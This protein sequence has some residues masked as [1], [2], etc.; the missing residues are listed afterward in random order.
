MRTTKLTISAISHAGI[1]LVFSTFPPIIRTAEAGPLEE[2]IVTAQKREQS[3]QEVGVS[4]TAFGADG[5]RDLGFAESTDIAAQTPGLNIGTPV[6]EGNNP[7]IVLR[8][9][10]LNDFND[11]NEGPV[12]LYK[13]GVYLG[14]M[15]GQTF[16]LFDI[17]RVEV[18][19]GPQGTLYGR[20]TTGGLV[21]FISNRPTEENDASLGISYGSY[22]QLKLEGALGGA[23]SEDIRVRF[24]MTANDHEGYVE[25]RIG[26]DGNEGYNFAARMLAEVD[27][28][29]NSSLLF[30]AHGGESDVIAPKYEHEVTDTSFDPSGNNT[31]DFWGYR[32]TDG[33]PHKGDYDRDGVLE[34]GTSG[35]SVTLDWELANGT[36]FVIISGYETLDKLHKEDT[37]MG[38]QPGIEP[39]FAA[40]YEQFSHEIRFSGEFGRLGWVAGGYYFDSDVEGDYELEV[41]HFGPFLNFLNQLPA[42]QGGFE[43]GLGAGTF[44]DDSLTQFL[45]YDVDYD[46]G[47]ESYALFGQ[48]E[49]EFAE[50]YK[51]TLGVRYTREERDYEYVNRAG[52]NRGVFIDFLDNVMALNDG[53]LFDYRRGGADVIAGNVN[54]IEDDNMSGQLGLDWQV[55]EDLL[56][57]ASVR[58]GFKSGG[59]NA[60]F[61]DTDMQAARDMFGINVQYDDEVLSAFEVGLKS[62]WADNRA[63]FN[64]SAFYY[65]YEDFQALSFFGFSQF[66]VNSDAEVFG[67]EL[68]LLA[69]PTEALTLQFGANFLDTEVDQVRNL[70][71]G[72]LL[73]NREMVLAPDFSLNGLARY[74]WD[75]RGDNLA[76]QIDFNHQG[77][78][79]FDITNQDIARESAYTIW[80]ARVTW[81]S[82]NGH[83]QAAVFGK[84][85]TDEEY[86]VY[87]FDFTGPGGFNQQFFG[88]PQWFGGS[89]L[90]RF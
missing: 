53:I 86:R 47:T 9:V 69:Q 81:T 31:G 51:L 87:T 78:H 40:D 32:D 50:D 57:Y 17:E 41:R 60:G 28:G 1:A 33:D 90:Y 72:E 2:V 85:I 3:L 20:N 37:D 82:A 4:V 39:T 11:N 22:N 35:L 73:R 61:M 21:H 38:P 67:A 74:E 13:D 8:G 10:G 84:N 46:Q 23:L 70:N 64:A 6:G 36:D 54:R 14:A 7:S 62:E 42:L 45:H 65:D 52:S 30:N 5:L 58:Q 18:L 26:R 34:I 29:E 15:A 27:L 48:A 83:W 80:N 25:N 75:L 63:R 77:T 55:N 56:L 71:T 59:F 49:Y 88:R 16:Q 24:A 68:E 44:P 12:A 19:R 66:I 76:A 89:I 79:Y 43:G